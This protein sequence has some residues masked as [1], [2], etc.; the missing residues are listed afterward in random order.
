MIEQL[1]EKSVTV[2][3]GTLALGYTK[4]GNDCLIMATAHIAHDCVIGDRVIIVNGVG[5]AG[6]I[7]IKD[8]A[9][10]GGMVAVHQFTQIGAHSLVAGGALVRKDIPPYVKAA[11]EPIAY[12]GVNSLGLYR[13]GFDSDQVNTIRNIYRILFQQGLPS[14]KAVEKIQK[15]FPP[16]KEKQTILNFVKHSERGIIKGYNNE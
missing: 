16:S 4:I 5:L 11:R 9:I 3:K 10:L 7:N 15:T 6:H 8:Y 12:A 1:F 14:T 13:R 2:N